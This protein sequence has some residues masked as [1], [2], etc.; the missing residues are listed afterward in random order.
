MGY[1]APTHYRKRVRHILKP[2]EDRVSANLLKNL[3]KED[4]GQIAKNSTEKLSK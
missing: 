4:L 3:S 2:L 1:E